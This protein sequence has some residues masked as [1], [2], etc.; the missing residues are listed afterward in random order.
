VS[1]QVVIRRDRKSPVLPVSSGLG[2]GL[3]EIAG[4]WSCG[5]YG[6][7]PRFW[8]CSAGCAGVF[9]ALVKVRRKKKGGTRWLYILLGNALTSG[10]DNLMTHS[11]TLF[12]FSRGPCT[13]VQLM[14]MCCTGARRNS[15]YRLSQRPTSRSDDVLGCYEG[16]ARDRK[17]TREREREKERCVRY[18]MPSPRAELRY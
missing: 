2:S 16:R 8:A 1:K 6:T 15:V 10:A 9:V 12:V 18:R 4:C 5:R 7:N 3:T 14:H 13:V 17:R 11:K